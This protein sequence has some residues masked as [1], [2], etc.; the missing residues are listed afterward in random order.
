[1]WS[2]ASG[3]AIGGRHVAR[4]QPN[5]DAHVSYTPVRAGELAFVAVADGHGS[6]ACP[7]SSV[8]SALAVD[9]VKRGLRGRTSL[10]EPEPFMRW[11]VEN[12][13]AEVASDLKDREVPD[14]AESGPLLYGTTLLVAAAK[15]SQMFVA[16]IG[17]GEFVHRSGES[18][19]V[20]LAESELASTESESLCM[21]DAEERICSIAFDIKP[22]ESSMLLA[23][24]DGFG[25][26]FA[27]KDWH[28]SVTGEM[29]LFIA[30]NNA[31][32]LSEVVGEWCE[33]PAQ[34]GGDDA[35]IGILE[36]SNDES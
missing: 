19:K 9:V 24:T 20:L 22:N 11:V 8:G 13:R 21:A 31:S 17:D 5:E 18:V 7:F 1:M 23:A 25:G 29:L 10:P 34:V 33:E 36:W 14:G 27:D 2:A 35:S 4:S 3:T 15:D 12:W 32:E 26:A 30:S 6:A 28:A 16:R